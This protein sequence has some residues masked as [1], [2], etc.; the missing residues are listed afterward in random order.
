[1]DFMLYPTFT[2]C[3]WRIIPNINLPENYQ[4]LILNFYEQNRKKEIEKYAKKIHE[5][6]TGKRLEIKLKWDSKKGLTNI[7]IGFQGGLDLSEQLGYPHFA[8]HNLTTET[9]IATGMIA[10]KYISELLKSK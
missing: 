6:Y 7:N 5:K 4:K 8:E 10:M 9:S 2:I 1:M 3:D